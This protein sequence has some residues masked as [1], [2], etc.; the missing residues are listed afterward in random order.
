M[1]Q[2][3]KI[4]TRLHHLT[5]YECYHVYYRHDKT[6]DTHNFDPRIAGV[7]RDHWRTFSTAS[8]L[9]GPPDSAS[10]AEP[11]DEVPAEVEPASGS[12]HE[13]EPT[14]ADGAQLSSGSS[15]S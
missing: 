9:Q 6:H 7:P 12:E 4:E 10:E 11:D 14:D 5:P 3:K 13:D 1:Q 15:S 2:V 8:Q